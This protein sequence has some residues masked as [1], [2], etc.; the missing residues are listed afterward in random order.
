MKS[1]KCQPKKDFGSRIILCPKKRSL[2]NIEFADVIHEMG[3]RV[4]LD[5]YNYFM[6]L[7][8]PSQ[9]RRGYKQVENK[10]K[11][12]VSFSEEIGK[13]YPI[14]PPFGTFSRER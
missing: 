5:K 7:N 9:R 2:L 14:V 1:K 11:C 4:C 3:K 8:N 13:N 10:Q 12:R 6:R